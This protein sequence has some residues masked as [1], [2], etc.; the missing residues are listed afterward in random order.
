VWDG[1]GIGKRWGRF[2]LRSDPYHAY[3]RRTASTAKRCAVFD[4][5]ATFGTGMLH[6]LKVSQ[7][8]ESRQPHDMPALDPHSALPP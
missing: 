3:L 6:A 8:S 1:C 4:R 7:G 2:G 5:R